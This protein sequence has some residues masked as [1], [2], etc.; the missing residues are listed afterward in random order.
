MWFLVLAAMLQN[1]VITPYCTKVLFHFVK[2][3]KKTTFLNGFFICI[4][5]FLSEGT[6]A[7][8]TI[9]RVLET[10]EVLSSFFPLDVTLLSF[11]TNVSLTTSKWNLELMA[12]L[13]SVVIL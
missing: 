11:P 8:H 4:N 6:H 7:A 3:I 10:V 5:L 13:D 12:R 9:P 2:K 1:K